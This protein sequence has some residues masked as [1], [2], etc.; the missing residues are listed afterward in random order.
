LH[1]V[2]ADNGG[3]ETSDAWQDE[4]VP[5]IVRAICERMAGILETGENGR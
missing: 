4:A 2:C 3:W 5:F 1:Y